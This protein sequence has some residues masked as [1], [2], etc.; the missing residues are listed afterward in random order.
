VKIPAGTISLNRGA[1]HLK[2]LVQ[3]GEVDLD[4]IE[5]TTGTDTGSAFSA[6]QPDASNGG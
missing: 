4:W 5:V 1:N 6:N 3:Q 2:W